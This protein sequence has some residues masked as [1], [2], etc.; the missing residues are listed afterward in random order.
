MSR[1]HKHFELSEGECVVTSLR[2]DG[3]FFT[4][5]QEY[6]SDLVPWQFRYQAE[7][8]DWVA[9]EFFRM[10]EGTKNIPW[11][12]YLGEVTIQAT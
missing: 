9:T 4:N 3:S 10:P 2:D 5:I 12:K 8:N 7:S 6:S 1:L 11:K